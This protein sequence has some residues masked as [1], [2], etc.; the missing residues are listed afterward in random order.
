MAPMCHSSSLLSY[1]VKTN[2]QDTLA[3]SQQDSS[4]DALQGVRQ[5][6]DTCHQSSIVLLGVSSHD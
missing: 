3:A 5:V 2:I 4:L 1:R 6:V